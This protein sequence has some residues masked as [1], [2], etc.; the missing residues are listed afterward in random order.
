MGSFI[1]RV[2]RIA[3][4]PRPSIHVTLRYCALETVVYTVKQFPIWCGRD[5]NFW[6]Q[7]AQ[8]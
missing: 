1:L 4:R 5:A 6:A 2:I 3:A 7:T 8:T